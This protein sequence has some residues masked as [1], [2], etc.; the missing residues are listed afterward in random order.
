MLDIKNIIDRLKNQGA[1]PDLH[2][3]DLLEKLK[4][5][6]NKKNTLFNNK[7]IQR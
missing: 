2:Q 4:N 1:N 7:K 6:V 3:I 5:L